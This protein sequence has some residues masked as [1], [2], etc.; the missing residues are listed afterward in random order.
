[1]MMLSHE[2]VLFVYRYFKKSGIV[3]IFPT[4]Y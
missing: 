4:Y 2:P 3:I 1:M